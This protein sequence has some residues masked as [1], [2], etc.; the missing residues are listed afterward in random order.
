MDCTRDADGFVVPSR[1]ASSKS[2]AQ[3]RGMAW[4]GSYAGSVGPSEVLWG[5]PNTGSGRSASK[6]LVEAYDYRVVN[7][8]FNGIHLRSP[9]D[10]LPNDI[11][12]LV[13]EVRKTC[14]PSGPTFEEVKGD[15][16]LYALAMVPAAE[17]YVK[18]HFNNRISANP[19]LLSELRRSDRQPMFKS[20][21]PR[22]PST[23]AKVSPPVPDMLYGYNRD[24]ALQPEQQRQVMSDMV[25]NTQ[26]LIYPFFTVEF[27]GD[28]PGG[29]GS[30]WVATNQCLGGSATCVSIAERQ[31]SE[32]RRSGSENIV[33][34][35]TAAF[36]LAMSGTEAR[37]HVSW[38]DAGSGNHYM[39]QIECFVLQRPE[40]SI[41][42]R[43]Y[44]LSIINWG[45]GERLK[46]IRA[47]LDMLAEEGRKRAAKI[48]SWPALSEGGDSSVGSVCS[49]GRKRQR[50][51]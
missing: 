18:E 27:K 38:R 22:A 33:P 24:L 2:P 25:V 28:S 49:G 31:N 6:S 36:S 34:I 41:E 20:M 19:G 9:C 42:L 15:K 45:I 50:T 13:N 16:A 17:S 48:Q 32:L 51:R 4:S 35:P 11:A 39:Q 44:V 40:H 37:L 23:L 12:A 7:L 46:E 30:L 43:N 3:A 26:N 10:S 1:P 5:A 47:S 29:A 21:V 8:A 14:D